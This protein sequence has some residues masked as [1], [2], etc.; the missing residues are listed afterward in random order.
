AKWKVLGAVEL[1]DSPPTASGI[2][3]IMGMTRQAA[4]KQIGLLVDHG[5]LTPHDNP[6]DARAAVYT[7][8]PEGQAIYAAI[9]AA[10]AE[11]VEVL[12]ASISDL[13]SQVRSPCWS[14][15]LFNWNMCAH[16]KRQ[17]LPHLAN[18]KEPRNEITRSRN[19]WQHCHAL[20]F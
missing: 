15:L 13:K 10:W 19:F 6:L 14:S 9:S 17:K 7:L 11:K 1:S 16:P 2:G 3:R 5:L 8:S 4:T 20:H 12:R 18:I